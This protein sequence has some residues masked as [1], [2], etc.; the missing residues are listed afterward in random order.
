MGVTAVGPGTRR[1]GVER[2]VSVMVLAAQA[3]LA[4]A[5]WFGLVVSPTVRDWFELDAGR[6]DV[7]SAF[8]LADLVVIVVGSAVAAV[9]VARDVSWAARCVAWVAGGFAYAAL[10]LLVWMLLVWM[11]FG[12]HGAAGLPPMIAGTVTTS[13]VARRQP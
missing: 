3:G 8:F 10:Y 7:L 13:V 2:R 4:L 6:R 12:G 1:R 11:A 5:S 9:A